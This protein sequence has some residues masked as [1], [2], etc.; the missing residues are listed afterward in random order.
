MEHLEELKQLFSALQ[1]L[2]LVA[3]NFTLPF[4]LN[5]T[6]RNILVGFGSV[7]ACGLVRH[8]A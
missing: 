3:S 1:I 6:N 4:Q 2:E 5:Q 8:K 7:W